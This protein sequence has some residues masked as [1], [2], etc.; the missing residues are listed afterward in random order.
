MAVK[1]EE[2]ASK[3]EERIKQAIDAVVEDIRVSIDDV[4]EVVNQQFDAALQSVVADAKSISLREDLES[5]LAEEAPDEPIEETAVADQLPPAATSSRVLSRAIQEIERGSSQVDVLNSLLD[6]LLKF[7]SRTALLILKGDTFT[8]WKG[9]GFAEF[10]GNDEAIKRFSASPGQVG[11]LDRLR[12][13]EFPVV[14]DGLSFSQ[15]A[16]IERPERA[17]A[18]PMV[19][20]DKVAAAVYIDRMPE[21]EKPFDQAAVELL[22]FTTGLL[23]DTL[24]IR[25]KTPSPTWSR[26]ED[27]S[28]F[29]AGTETVV[30]REPAPPVEEAERTVAIEPPPPPPE[31]VQEIPEMPA[32][33]ELEVP[34]PSPAEPPEP[35]AESIPE[36]APEHEEPEPEPVAP[37]PPP[38]PP[39][40]PP[41]PAGGGGSTQYVPPAGIQGR[42]SAADVSEDAKKHD[43]AR[44]FAR[45]LVSEIKLYNE[46]KVD[47]GRKNR[48]LYERLKEDIDRSR[49]MYDDR[50]SPE[51]REVSN[52][53]YDELVRILADGN[54][55][56]LGL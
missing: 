5:L 41:P 22:I 49:Q 32:E 38:A 30:L 52:Y 50:V 13:D 12:L 4:R 27:L 26:E 42:A 39:V 47:Q 16:S 36:V 35:E 19:I 14:W 2:I 21:S 33:P 43:D 10:G 20:K 45:L 25:K 44:R 40:Q 31:P 56:A 23:I 18:V 51:V 3:L 1:G 54:A 15:R 34:P 48:D 7:G 46:G 28:P 9:K 55:D 17:V 24:A 29:E 37:S 11:E 6:Q 8:G 53:F